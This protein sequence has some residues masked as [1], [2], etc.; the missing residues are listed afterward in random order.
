MQE[1]TLFID[2]GRVVGPIDPRLYSNFTEHMGRL[3]Y[4]G[5]WDP[6]SKF[7]DPNTG[8]RQDVIDELKAIKVRER[9]IAL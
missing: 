3:I 7:S 4:G 1:A 9:A 5:L 8:F 2:P 6:T